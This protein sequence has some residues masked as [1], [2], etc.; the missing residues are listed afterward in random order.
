MNVGS[1]R[2]TTVR[3]LA[4]TFNRYAPAP[5]TIRYDDRRPGDVV[6]CYTDTAKAQRML[7]WRPRYDVGAAIRDAL[8]WSRRWAER[9]YREDSG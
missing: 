1:G 6:G 9:R 2:A 8:R 3:Q 5:V 7:A 4:D